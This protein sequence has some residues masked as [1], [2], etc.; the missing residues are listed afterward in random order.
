MDD[1]ASEA[2]PTVRA[3]RRSGESRKAAG[4]AA[5]VAA[6]V[7]TPLWSRALSV[8]TAL[9]L[10]L[11]ALWVLRR[12]AAHV[13]LADLGRELADIGWMQ[14]ALAVVFTGL[15]FLALIGYEY[16]AVRFARHRLPMAVVGLYS[17]ITQ[18]IS[19]A[20]G[21]AIFVGA[22]VRWKLYGWHG[23]GLVD[24]VKIQIYFTTT[25]GLGVLTLGGSALLLEPAPL[26]HAVGSDALVWRL[27]GALLLLLVATVVFVGAVMHRRLRI[28]GHP[29]ELPD[30]PVTMLLIALGVGDLLGVAGAFHMLLPPELGLR[31]SESLSIFVAA[32]S[33]GLVSHVPGSLGVFEGAV[34]LIVAPVPELAAPLIGALVAFR[35]V[36]YMLPLVL[37]A[38]ALAVV[39]FLRWRRAGH[40]PRQ[41]LESG[42][43]ER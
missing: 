40:E 1:V 3:E 39:E 8:L 11:L 32:L 42:A 38:T 41:I 22:T 10:L 35:A 37:G 25:F 26:A 29:V 34:V 30:P 20:A 4:T 19:H 7:A 13:T 24:V 21:F 18:S 28:F 6:G 23:L 17:F 31:F 14:I 12:W 9:A 43:A 27:V 16:H 15:S 2:E 33:L 5:P 36:Y